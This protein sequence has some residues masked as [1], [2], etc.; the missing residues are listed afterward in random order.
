MLTLSETPIA[1][2]D[3]LMKA[4]GDVPALSGL[5]KAVI[6]LDDEAKVAGRERV[7]DVDSVAEHTRGFDDFA[8]YCR[9]ISWETIEQGSGLTRGKQA[10]RKHPARSGAFER[11]GAAHRGN[12]GKAAPR[13]A[14]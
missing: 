1:A 3:C 11:S 14:R 4:G 7:L 2:Q 13:S 12:H 10:R 8:A 6:A 5:C 9:N